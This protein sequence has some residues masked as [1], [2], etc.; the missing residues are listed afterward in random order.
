MTEAAVKPDLYDIK[1]CKN[2]KNWQCVVSDDGTFC[3]G[4]CGKF[5][6]SCYRNDYSDPFKKSSCLCEEDV[7][8]SMTSRL[9]I[10]ISHPTISCESCESG[11]VECGKNESCVCFAK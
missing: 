6:F 2:F 1:N 9:H 5:Q 8:G 10:S 3:Q 11:F 4:S 7:N